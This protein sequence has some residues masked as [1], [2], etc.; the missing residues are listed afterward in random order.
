MKLF[1]GSTLLAFYVVA[2]TTYKGIGQYHETPLNFKSATYVRVEK[3]DKPKSFKWGA[4][5]C[6]KLDDKIYCIKP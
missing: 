4:Y 6:D 2:C 5:N 1:I 3:D